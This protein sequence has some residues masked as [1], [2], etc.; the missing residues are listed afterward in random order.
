MRAEKRGSWTRPTGQQ[1]A[2]VQRAAQG[3]YTRAVVGD[4]PLLQCIRN[5]TVGLDPAQRAH[6]HSSREPLRFPLS[7]LNVSEWE[8]VLSPE[9]EAAPPEGQGVVPGRLASFVVRLVASELVAG[10]TVAQVVLCVF[11]E[12]AVWKTGERRRWRQEAVVVVLVERRS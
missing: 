12:V 9:G 4:V 8:T 5:L 11:V 10:L 6:T 2:V 7:T 1:L 3:S